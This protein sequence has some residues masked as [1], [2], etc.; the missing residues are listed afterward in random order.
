MRTT[1]DLPDA[2][3]RDLKIKAAQDGVSLK[4]LV[5]KFVEKCLYEPKVEETTPV[6][7]LLPVFFEATGETI[8]AL[9][10]AELEE[11]FS[12]EDLGHG[13]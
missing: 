3:F 13:E 12:G 7:S 9:S 10:N 8:P 2:V 1:L 5:T 6:R 4:D 11:I